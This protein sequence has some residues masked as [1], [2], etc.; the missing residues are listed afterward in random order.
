MIW[1]LTIRKP[2][3]IATIGYPNF[4][5]YYLIKSNIKILL[6]IINILGGKI[7]KKKGKN[8][9]ILFKN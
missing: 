8:I 4:K 2:F 1:I 6:F 5:K 9:R 3:V 7:Y